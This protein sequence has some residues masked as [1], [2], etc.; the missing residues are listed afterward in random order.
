MSFI[1]SLFYCFPWN[2]HRFIITL[3]LLSLSSSELRVVLIMITDTLSWLKRQHITDIALYQR[4]HKEWRNRW[5]HNIM[6]PCECWSLLLLCSILL[7]E[8]ITIL[9]GVLLATLALLVTAHHHRLVGVVAG[10]FYLT[11]SWTAN[12][13]VEVHSS[14]PTIVIAIAMTLWTLAWTTQVGIGHFIIE[15]NVPNL[16]TFNEVSYMAMGLSVLVA[17]TS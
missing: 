3:S 5:I 6:I 8:T 17:W 16:A 15:K 10:S 12:N 4:N 7:G 2:D 9:I 11:A 14:N 13:M 1:T